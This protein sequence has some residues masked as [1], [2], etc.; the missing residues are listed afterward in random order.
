LT[1]I[2][3]ERQR[4]H[5]RDS[6][7]PQAPIGAAEDQALWLLASLE[8]DQLMPERNDL[9]LYRCLVP[10]ASEKRTEHH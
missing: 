8:H 2:R 3:A 6:P 4:D 9:G 5:N 10:K 1:I 7:N